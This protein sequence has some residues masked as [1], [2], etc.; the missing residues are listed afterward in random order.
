MRGNGPEPEPAPSKA[1]QL[2]ELV[3]ARLFR[4]PL[5][6]ADHKAIEDVAPWAAC[7]DVTVRG[8]KFV[9]QIIEYEGK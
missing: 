1:H 6:P 3:A 7:F 8:S 9:I 4:R 5:T 2:A